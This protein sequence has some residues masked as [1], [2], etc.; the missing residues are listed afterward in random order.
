MMK[1]VSSVLI[2][3]FLFS[4]WLSAQISKDDW[5]AGGN[6]RINTA[7]NNSQFEFSPSI[8]YFLMDGLA[9]GARLSYQMEKLGSNSVSGLGFGPFAR[10]YFG[11]E[12]FFPFFEGAFDLSNRKYKT[13]TLTTTEQAF[14]LF[15]GGGLAIFLNENVA[16]EGMLGYRNSRVKNQSGNG[17]LNLR[18]GFQVYLNRG[19]VERVRSKLSL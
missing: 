17:G 11:S 4:G 13:G 12:K 3:I 15:G 2:A 10:Y 14:S 1:K 16:L 6:L 7:K 19:Q 9:M 18:I 5:M 8:G